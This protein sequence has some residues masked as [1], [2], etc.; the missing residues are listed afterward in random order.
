[1]SEGVRAIYQNANASEDLASLDAACYRKI[2]LRGARL[3]GLEFG[4]DLD[5]ANTVDFGAQRSNRNRENAKLLATLKIGEFSGT[6]LTLG[7]RGSD[8]D[9]R[10]C[11]NCQGYWIRKKIA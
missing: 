11:A 1:M 8:H 3:S 9:A 4:E 10:R 6:G 7:A 2:F 5:V